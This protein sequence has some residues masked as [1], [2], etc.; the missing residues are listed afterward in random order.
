MTRLMDSEGGCEPRPSLRR[1]P[2]EARP[3]VRIVLGSTV[4]RLV[5]QLDLGPKHE[6]PFVRGSAQAIDRATDLSVASED[7]PVALGLQQE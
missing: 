6:E 1:E 5:Q 2:G 7:P 3:E 4:R